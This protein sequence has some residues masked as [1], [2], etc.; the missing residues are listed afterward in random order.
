MGGFL[1]WWG[2]VEPGMADGA[3]FCWIDIGGG[4]EA[5]FC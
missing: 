5:A 3:A 2:L 1:L 4:D